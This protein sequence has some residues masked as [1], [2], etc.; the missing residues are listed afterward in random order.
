MAALLLVVSLL[1]LVL[2]T[3]INIRETRQRMLADTEALLASNAERLT[4]HLDACQKGYLRSVNQLSNLPDVRRYCEAKEVERSNHSEDVRRIMEV[5][6]ASDAN[7]RR[8]AMLDL[9]GKVILS[10]ENKLV[11]ADLSRHGF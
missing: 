10:T 3:W 11:G 7:I 5:W 9:N 8:V 6:L 4:D 2:A 1:P